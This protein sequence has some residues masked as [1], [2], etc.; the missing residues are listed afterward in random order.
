MNAYIQRWIVDIGDKV[1]K[2]DVLATLFVPELVEDHATKKA[3]VAL[4]QERIVLAKVVVQV[5]QADVD[6]ALAR[7]E[8]ARAEL[9]GCQAEVVWQVWQVCAK[10]P[11][12]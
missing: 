2:G 7:V 9:A 1:K 10:P 5:A 3:T 8:E 4:D 11:A 6:A 12:T